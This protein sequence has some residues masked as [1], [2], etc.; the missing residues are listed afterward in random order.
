M[1]LTAAHPDAH[2]A[3]GERHLQHPGRIRT[4]L[5]EVFTNKTPTDA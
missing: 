5:T 2:H 3:D 4:T 1:L